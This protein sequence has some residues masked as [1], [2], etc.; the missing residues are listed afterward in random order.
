[1]MTRR[2]STEIVRYASDFCLSARSA[3]PTI[4]IHVRMN[5]SPDTGLVFIIVPLF[6]NVVK[7]IS[8]FHPLYYFFSL[9]DFDV[10]LCPHSSIFTS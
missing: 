2:A 9:F 10:V 7:Q 3:A 1:M 6:F 4:L 8:E 5:T